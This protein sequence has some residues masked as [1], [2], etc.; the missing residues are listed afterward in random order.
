M[1][2]Y[3]PPPRQAS[4]DFLPYRNR[5]VP[6]VVGTYAKEPGG[7]RTHDRLAEIESQQ[8]IAAQ[9]S[10]LEPFASGRAPADVWKRLSIDRRHAGVRELMIVTLLPTGRIGN[11]FDPESVRNDWRA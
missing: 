1:S 8:A 6:D 9:G 2:P 5:A 10:A 7:Q 4:P 3:D 11:Q